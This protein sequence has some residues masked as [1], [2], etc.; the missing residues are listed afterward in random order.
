VLLSWSESA[1]DMVP[2][3]GTWEFQVGGSSASVKTV[4]KNI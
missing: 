1:C 2:T 3:H 4:T